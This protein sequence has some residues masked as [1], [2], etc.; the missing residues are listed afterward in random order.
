LTRR[1]EEKIEKTEKDLKARSL[2]PEPKADVDRLGGSRSNGRNGAYKAVKVGGSG[3]QKRATNVVAIMIGDAATAIL[4]AITF[5][6]INFHAPG[7]GSRIVR[8]PVRHA[9]I[10]H[11]GAR[12]DDSI[13]S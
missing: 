9:D 7:R 6:A 10:E 4:W 3:L 2:T 5:E 1:R 13:G 12:V 11:I 8:G